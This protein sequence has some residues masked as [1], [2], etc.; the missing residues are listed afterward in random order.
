M[1]P[2]AF[3]GPTTTRRSG[4]CTRERRG[5]K[6][7]PA[8]QSPGKRS[9]APACSVRGSYADSSSA[10]STTDLLNA[11]AR[12]DQKGGV[13]WSSLLILN[14]PA[15]CHSG[16]WAPSLRVE[17]LSIQL[18][19]ADVLARLRQHSR[20]FRAA[21]HRCR[22]ERP[23]LPGD[24][25]RRHSERAGFYSA[26]RI[27]VRR[28]AIVSRG[29]R[30]DLYVIVNARIDAGFEVVPNQIEAIAARSFTHHE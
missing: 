8:A 17:G 6:L 1:A 28:Q 25:R 12:E 21:A 3:L 16:T 15:R 14:A 24:A 7:D 20:S 29:A 22:G 9:S 11:I 18:F 5:G 2:F 27:S 30:P 13:C 19:P 4:G 10:K 23:K 26:G